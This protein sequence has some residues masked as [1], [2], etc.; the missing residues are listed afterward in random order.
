MTMRQEGDRGPSLKVVDIAWRYVGK[1]EFLA[2][3]PAR[4]LTAEEAAGREAEIEGSGLYERVEL[5]EVA[6]AFEEFHETLDKLKG[7]LAAS[8]ARATAGK[9]L[10]FKGTG[11]G[12]RTGR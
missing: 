1:G 7:E 11:T 3:V 2:G 8:E 12:P 9:V 6:E 4:G 10:P 5:D